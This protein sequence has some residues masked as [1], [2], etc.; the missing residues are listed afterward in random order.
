MGGGHRLQESGLWEPV[1]PAPSALHTAGMREH[2]SG[3]WSLLAGGGS[4]RGQGAEGKL[5][6]Q[7]TPV[8][9]PT[10][11]AAGAWFCLPR[12]CSLDA[13][14]DCSPHPGEGSRGIGDPQERATLLCQ[15][16]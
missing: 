16:P 11:Q 15:C 12:P 9:F 2:L 3:R 10:R 8:S 6:D 14:R 13:P 1:A 5:R 7:H 4:S